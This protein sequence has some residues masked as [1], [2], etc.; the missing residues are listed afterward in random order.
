MWRDCLTFARPIDG[1]LSNKAVRD[2]F[3]PYGNVTHGVNQNHLCL[4]R[5]T[6][7]LTHE[8]KGYYHYTKSPDRTY[9]WVDFTTEAEAKHTIQ[10]MRNGG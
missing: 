5:L 6:P 7:L 9:G 1:N 3:V 10:C 4:A 8:F 2:L